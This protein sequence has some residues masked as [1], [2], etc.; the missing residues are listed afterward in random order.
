M[1]KTSVVHCMV[2][3]YDVYIGRGRCPK[4][5]R[6]SIW[7]NPYSHKHGTAAKH[8][9]ASVE[10]A[11]EKY[12]EYV[13]ATPELME[14]LGELRGKS[15]GCWCFPSKCHGDILI[16]LINEKFGEDDGE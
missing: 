10:E 7:G 6:R 14:R 8:V 4:M 1:K 5:K 13:R 3:E 9:V 12:E 2:S 11:I 16:K 15:L